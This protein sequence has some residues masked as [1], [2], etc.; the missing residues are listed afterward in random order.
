MPDQSGSNTVRCGSDGQ[1][2]L[3]R[4]VDGGDIA[5]P[6]QRHIQRAGD[7]GGGQGQHIHFGAQLLEMFLVGHAETLLFI[8]D[9]QSEVLELHILLR[10]GGGCR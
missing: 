10:S 9:H 3:G 4:R 1:P 2:F 8:D 5:H 6:G 7:G